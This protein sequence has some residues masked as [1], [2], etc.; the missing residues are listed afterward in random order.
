MGRLVLAGLRRARVRPRMATDTFR[1]RSTR[2]GAVDSDGDAAARFMT[3]IF[4]R[5]I[6]KMGHSAPIWLQVRM[7]RIL[8]EW[9]T[10]R[11]S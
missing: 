8:S 5:V 10:A 2:P 4:E 7:L 11:D 6:A 1:R 3:A 9:A